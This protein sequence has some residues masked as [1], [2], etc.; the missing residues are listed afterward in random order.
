MNEHMNGPW[1][2]VRARTM[3]H[4]QGPNGYFGVSIRADSRAV[5]VRSL[6]AAAPILLRE[7]CDANTQM[8]MAAE[9]IEAGRHDEA[10]LHVLSMSRKRIA[11][12]VAATGDT[13]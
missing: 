5:E 11:A 4:L 3:Y 8:E 12:I 2:W 7:L 13:K 1:E 6:I 10:L 9:C